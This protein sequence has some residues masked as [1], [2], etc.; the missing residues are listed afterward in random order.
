MLIL[1][2]VCFPFCLLP[3]RTF[4]LRLMTI[5][6]FGK[7]SMSIVLFCFIIVRERPFDF[8]G[9]G[10]QE[11]FPNKNSRTEFFQKKISRTG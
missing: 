9:G 2:I 3:F 4:P 8:Y 5:T 7:V 1:R 6:F 10:G 11:D